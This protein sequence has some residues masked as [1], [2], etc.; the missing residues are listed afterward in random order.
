MSDRKSNSPFSRFLNSSESAYP[1]GSAT[2][3]NDESAVCFSA[4]QTEPT[5]HKTLFVGDSTPTSESRRAL[6]RY[7]CANVDG[8]TVKMSLIGSTNMEDRFNGCQPQVHLS[9]EEESYH[10]K[11]MRAMN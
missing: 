3:T 7:A 5:V 8:C 11:D 9:S 2:P 10:D 1:I 4:Q 6:R